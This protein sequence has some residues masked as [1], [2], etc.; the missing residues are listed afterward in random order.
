MIGLIKIA[1]NGL[2]KILDLLFN[3]LKWVTLIQNI[4]VFV[5]FLANS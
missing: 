3:Y 1:N 2:I 4:F 5:A